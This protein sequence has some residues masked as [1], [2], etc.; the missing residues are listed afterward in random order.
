LGEYLLWNTETYARN[1]VFENE[2][3][4]I[5]ALCWEPGQ[6]TPIHDH[7]GEEC[8][9]Y[10]VDGTLEETRYSLNDDETFRFEKRHQCVSGDL[11]Y[12]NNELGW[13]ELANNSEH[14]AISLHIYCKP[15]QSCRV[16]NDADLRIEE[17]EPTYFSKNGILLV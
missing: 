10:M 14:R 2:Q 12:M 1:C 13:H 15:I 11:G 9:V 16:Y 8:W 17:H 4:E 3:F 7:G 6:A 5:I